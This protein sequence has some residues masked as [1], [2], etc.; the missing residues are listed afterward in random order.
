MQEIDQHQAEK[1]VY[2][3]VKG[4]ISST[5]SSTMGISFELVVP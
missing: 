1:D 3:M 4:I 2:K 5:C